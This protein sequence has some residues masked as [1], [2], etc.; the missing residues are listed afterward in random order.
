MKKNLGRMNRSDDSGVA[1]VAAMG[2]AIIGAAFSMIVLTQAIQITNDAA[3]DRVRTVEVHAAEAVLDSTL[4]AFE[5]STPCSEDVGVVTVGEGTQAVNVTV[6]IDYYDVNDNPIVCS[7]GVL[8]SVPAWA[9][10][11]ADALPVQNPPV[12]LVPERNMEAR[13][14]L[15][16]I[17]VPSMGVA[18]FSGGT[19][20]IAN[21]GTIS[22]LDPNDTARVW[23][24]NSNF[25]CNNNVTINADL[26]VTDGNITLNNSCAVAGDAW[27]WGS[28]TANNVANPFRVYGDVYVYTGN[29]TNNNSQKYGGNVSVQGSISGASF[30]AVGTVC[31]NGTCPPMPLYEQ[32]GIPEVYYTPSDWPSSF[33]EVDLAGFAEEVIAGA[34]L[35]G[36]KA[37][38]YRSNPCAMTNQIKNPIDFPTEDRI[39]DLRS[40]APLTTANQVTFVINSDVA[41]FTNGFQANNSTTFQSGDGEQH[42]VWIIVPTGLSGD[43]QLS[44][45]SNIIDP[46]HVFLF[47]PNELSFANNQDFVGQ[48]YGTEVN[49]NNSLSF[50]YSGMGIPGV[51]LGDPTAGTTPEGYTVEIV[52]KHETSVY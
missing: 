12:G 21:S 49:A 3:R 11:S 6:T 18:I 34:G 17:E 26:I 31:S 45:T 23:V 10:V 30:T 28:F 16:P 33:V 46:I 42:D 43:I 38:A 50:L 37:S 5:T 41:F 36:S 7:G 19:M 44:N 52:S 4:K 15:I 24:E 47:T 20:Q 9:E 25:T 32:R 35:T 48:A 39:Y 14:N 22:P 40:C 8:S 51:E 13:V 29:M 27:A 2:V 1:L